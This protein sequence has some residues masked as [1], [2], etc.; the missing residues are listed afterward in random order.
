MVDQKLVYIKTDTNTNRNTNANM[1][2]N[3]NMNTNININTN[4]DTNIDTNLFAFMQTKI[5][6]GTMRSGRPTELDNAQ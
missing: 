2:T 5:K 6:G 1:N 4:T 3:T